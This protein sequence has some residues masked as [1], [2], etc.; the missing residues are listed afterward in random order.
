M[1]RI[2]MSRLVL[3]LVWGMVSALLCASLPTFAFL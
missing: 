3:G 1:A 2:W